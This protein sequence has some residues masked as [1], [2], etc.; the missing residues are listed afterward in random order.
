MIKSAHVHPQIH[1]QVVVQL[2]INKHTTTTN[3]F[4]SKCTSI[5]QNTYMY[6]RKY[7][8]IHITQE[9]V[10]VYETCTWPNAC[11]KTY[12]STF[13]CSVHAQSHVCEHVHA[14]IHVEIHTQVHVHAKLHAEIHTQHKYIHINEQVHLQADVQVN[15]Q[16]NAHVHSSHIY[17]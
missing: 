8:C 14:Q 17:L 15:S 11:E 7:K 10:Y 2:Y 6:M 3:I 1:T 12:T 13:T 9:H 4:T 16:V 5:F